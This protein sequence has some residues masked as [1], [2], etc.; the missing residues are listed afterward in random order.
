MMTLMHKRLSAQKIGRTV[1]QTV[2]VV[3]K[4][5]PAE[6]IYY[7]SSIINLAGANIAALMSTV[8]GGS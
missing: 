3:F 6:G 1:K 7:R 4:N 5:R 8:L 2:S